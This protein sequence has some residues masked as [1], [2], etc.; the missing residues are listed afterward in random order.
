MKKYFF[1]K[2]EAIS[3][4]IGVVCILI[5]SL[6]LIYPL[7]IFALPQGG[8]VVSGQA[9][10]SQPD[11][12]NMNINQGSHKA[13][14]NWQSF[15]IARPEAVRFFQP[16]A[17]SIALN[18]V[19]GVNPS[20]LY[21]LLQANGRIFLINPNGIMVGP[22]GVIDVN[23]FVA[24]TLNMSD[25]DFLAGNYTFSRNLQRTLTSIVNQGSI[26]AAQ[27]GFVSLLAPSVQNQGTIVANLGKVYIGSGEQVT[28]NFA[29]NELISFVV[30]GSIRD[31]V[32][33]LDG[34][35][36]DNSISNTG[37][38]SADGGEVILS[39]K[40]AYDAIKSVV[41]NEGIIEGNVGKASEFFLVPEGNSNFC[42]LHAAVPVC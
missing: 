2:K 28:L 19:I 23:A 24:S 3:F 18:R 4:L 7:Q 39:A 30:D 8:Q 17:S 10:I 40:T 26:R 6:L 21:G 32:L 9:S 35:P 22:T 42:D 37:T 1:R 12:N 20:L 33:G 13:V 36:L 5:F 38:I 41:N 14:L 34:K 25:E 27:G 16:S 11:K 29:G 31:Q 15:S